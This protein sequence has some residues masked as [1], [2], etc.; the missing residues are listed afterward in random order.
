[1]MEVCEGYDQETMEDAHVSQ[2]PPFMG[3]SETIGHT[4]THGDSRARGS[5]EDTSICV[6][7]LDDIHV[8]VDPAVHL[9]YMMMQEDIGAC[10]TIQGHM[11]MR[12]S[13]QEHAEVYSGIQ[14]DALDCREET[15]LVEHGYS[16]PLQQYIVLGDHLHSS[17]NYMSDDGGRVID[18]QVVELSTVVPDGWS[19]VM[20]T[21]IIHHGYQWMRFW[22]SPWD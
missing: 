21:A 6:P 19:L 15:Y 3:S 8:E 18:Q 4:H 7:G 10:M 2:G 1:M 12:D 9:G 14:G 13:S 22:S 16:S 11:M 20:S 17:S 5:Y